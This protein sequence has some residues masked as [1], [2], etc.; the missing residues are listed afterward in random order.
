MINT[1]SYTFSG[2]LTI[3]MAIIFLI[4]PWTSAILINYII[5]AYLIIDGV[6]LLIEAINMKKIR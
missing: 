6:T 3:L 2:V 1:G 5:A 4:L